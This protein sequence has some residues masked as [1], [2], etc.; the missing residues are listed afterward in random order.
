MILALIR[1]FSFKV[2]P[3]FSGGLFVLLVRLDGKD[4]KDV[5]AEQHED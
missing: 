3:A 2:K 1:K 4:A 5:L